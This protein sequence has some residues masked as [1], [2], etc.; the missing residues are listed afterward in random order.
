M[1][2]LGKI[3]KNYDL[4]SRE[5]P[6]N[7]REESENKS[8]K[9]NKSGKKGKSVKESAIPRDKSHKIEIKNE[10]PRADESFYAE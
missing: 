6:E 3:S 5:E 8:E 2:S 9:S 7:K 4:I 10:G 1:K